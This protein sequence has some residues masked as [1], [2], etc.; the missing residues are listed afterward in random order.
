MGYPAIYETDFPSPTEGL[1]LFGGRRRVRTKDPSFDLDALDATI[2]A[3]GDGTWELEIT[4]FA[5]PPYRT[6]GMTDAL[7]L[8]DRG[9]EAPPPPASQVPGP[10]SLVPIVT[11]VAIRGG[12]RRRQTSRFFTSRACSSI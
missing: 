4:D 3:Q 8:P 10:G 11:C 9:A 2:I 5:V 7:V 6:G 1:R 12:R